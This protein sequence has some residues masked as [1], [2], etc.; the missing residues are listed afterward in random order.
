MAVGPDVLAAWS[1]RLFRAER[2]RRP[3]EPLTD[4]EPGLTVE[5]AYQIQ[6]DVVQRKLELGDEVVG[7][8]IGLTSRPMQEM[9]GV[10]EPD[11]GHLFRSMAYASG[12]VIGY[13]LMQP[14]VE[15]EI[16]FVLNKDLK[17]PGLGIHDVLRATEYV[18]PAIEVVDS[19]IENWRIKLPDTVADNASSGC[20]VL[21]DRPTRVEDVDLQVV[22]MA[23][24]EDGEVV[25]TG[26]GAAVLGHP[27][28]GVA[29]LANKLSE[30]GTVLRAG[31]V[32]LSG[33]VSAAVNAKP[34][35]RYVV[36]FGRLGRVEAVFPE[37][38]GEA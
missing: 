20:F 32:V 15:A 4:Q 21:G 7:H 29:W 1:E 33:A 34:G 9:F 25:Q 30:F 17:G 28:L 19:R 22:G 12:A 31:H 16:A 13:P 10:G 27:A 35:S 6:L 26:A 5:D 2:E 3:V 36:N 11:Y 14:R 8:K 38:E 24:Y 37:R 23:L 18:V